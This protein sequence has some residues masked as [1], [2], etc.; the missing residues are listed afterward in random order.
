MKRKPKRIYFT[1]EERAI[2][3][4]IKQPK[5]PPRPPQPKLLD[6]ESCFELMKGKFGEY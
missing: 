5:R 2:L 4:G 6:M 1:A 3:E